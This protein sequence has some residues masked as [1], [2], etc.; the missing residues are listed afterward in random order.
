MP[1]PTFLSLALFAAFGLLG[2]FETARATITWSGNLDPA[3]PT[4]WTF[5]TDGHIGKTADGTLTVDGDSDLLS[6]IGYIAY[7]SGTTGHVTVTGEGSTWTNG[8]CVGSNL[9]IGRGGSGTLAVSDGGRLY[10]DFGYIGYETGSTGVATVDGAGSMWTNNSKVRVGY[11][12]AGT[13]AITGGG[14]VSDEVGN[15]GY[16][17]GSTGVATVDGAGSTWT[18]TGTLYVGLHGIGTLSITGGGSVFNGYASNGYGFIGYQSGS[19]GTV[20][21]DGAGSTWTNVSSLHVGCNGAGTLAIVGG[22]LVSVRDGLTIDYDSDGDS[23]INM[24]T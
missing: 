21:V 1:R 18:N 15:I 12:G 22:G 3:N 6:R 24:S 23:F 16:L 11:Y 10:D 9:Y 8:G 13:L 14:K 4:T 2:P 17:S 19:T 7:E 20:T 5:S